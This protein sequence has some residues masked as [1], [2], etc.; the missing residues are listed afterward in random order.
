[1]LAALINDSCAEQYFIILFCEPSRQR[2]W[3][4]IQIAASI[5]SLIAKSLLKRK[6]IVAYQFTV[7]EKMAEEVTGPSP[8]GGPEDLKPSE[9]SMYWP[10]EN[11]KTTSC[12]AKRNIELNT[13]IANI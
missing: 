4:R 11:E 8:R 5:R 1:M 9:K 6:P 12:S 3:V 2:R 10:E 13:S 7:G